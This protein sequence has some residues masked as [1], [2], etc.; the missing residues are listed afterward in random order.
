MPNPSITDS[1]WLWLALFTA[2]G[3]AALLATGG[4]FGKRQSGIER[5]YQARDWQARNWQA[6]DRQVQS[7][8]VGGLG[9]EAVVES[10]ARESPRADP[11]QVATPDYSTPKKTLV[12]LWP[13]A[14]VLGTLCVAS[15]VML[16]Y[17]RWGNDGLDP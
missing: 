16:C 11:Q 9:Q 3:L 1:P 17:S 15:L 4:K 10:E 7:Q 2:V 14:G 5:R 12:G 8:Q 13:L 6:P